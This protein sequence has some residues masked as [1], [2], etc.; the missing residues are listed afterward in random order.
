[1]H[2]CYKD[3]WLVVNIPNS[4]SVLRITKEISPSFWKEGRVDT[5]YPANNFLKR[6]SICNSKLLKELDVKKFSFDFNGMNII[7]NSIVFQIRTSKEYKWSMR[8]SSPAGTSLL[9]LID[10]VRKLI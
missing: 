3:N 5:T 8:D 7:I 2:Y 6:F 10:Y 1:M 4:S 9:E